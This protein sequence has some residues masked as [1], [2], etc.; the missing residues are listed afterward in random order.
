MTRRPEQSLSIMSTILEQSSIATTHT[1]DA[2]LLIPEGSRGVTAI[3]AG[4]ARED[5]SQSQHSTPGYERPTEE[6]GYRVN[7]TETQGEGRRTC[8]T[9][10]KEF[11]AN[12]VTSIVKAL[13]VSA[14][15]YS[16]YEVGKQEVD[17][18]RT[19][20]PSLWQGFLAIEC[21]GLVSLEVL[22]R[23]YTSKRIRSLEESLHRAQ[24]VPLRPLPSV[25]NV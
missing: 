18:G 23:L 17:P 22:D 16:A 20:H 25:N 10:T 8:T 5:F 14:I 21:A 3:P 6:Q 12:S 24:N 1:S 19:K 2:A 13:F 7:D 9:A 4:V 11:L 15:A